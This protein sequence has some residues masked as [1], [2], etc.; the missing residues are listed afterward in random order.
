MATPPIS[1][2][3]IA[4][5]VYGQTPGLQIVALGAYN[6]RALADAQLIDFSTPTLNAQIGALGSIWIN[7]WYNEAPVVVLAEQTGQ[8][9]F[10]PPYSVGWYPL[11]VPPIVR[12]KAFIVPPRASYVEASNVSLCVCSATL[13][14][15]PFL[16]PAPLTLQT[17][18]INAAAVTATPIVAAVA[19]QVVRL[20][21]GRIQTNNAA[22]FIS[23]VDGVGITGSMNATP[24]NPLNFDFSGTPYFTSSVGGTLSVLG[25]H[26][27]DGF[28]QYTQGQ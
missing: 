17:A 2:P 8:S 28:L 23:F 7:N 21:R 16:N 20:W 19:G 26:Q 3:R 9:V 4:D 1:A 24:T 11:T 10:A 6:L 13:S 15:D 14:Q 27:T 12:L 22:G 5:T 18:I 25:S